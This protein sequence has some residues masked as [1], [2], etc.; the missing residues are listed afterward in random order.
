M[1]DLWDDG[2]ALVADG[3]HK[4]RVALAPLGRVAR[5][6]VDAEVQLRRSGVRL[7]L[8]ELVLKVA[9]V[10]RREGRADVDHLLGHVTVDLCK[11]EVSDS[12]L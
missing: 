8:A 5:G 1:A 3:V 9:R 4:R 7:K 10:P 2:A 11:T 6:L 12:S